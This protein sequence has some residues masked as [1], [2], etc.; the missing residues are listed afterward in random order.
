MRIIRLEVRAL[1]RFHELELDLPPGVTVIRGPNEAGK[2][3]VQRAIELALTR[4]AT[5]SWAELDQ[6]RP[7]DGRSPEPPAV[8]LE[9]V[10][11]EED[12]IRTGRLEK[13]FAGSKGT[14]RL[15]MNGEV[16]TDPTRA[17]E[18]LAELTGV[19]TEPFFRSTAS[20]HH[21]ELADLDR[22]EAN[23]RDRLQVTLSGADRGTSKAKKVLD[24]AIRDLTTRGEKNPGRL[25]VA[26]SAVAE[27]EAAMEAGEA[28]LA[29]LEHD[30]DALTQARVHRADVDGSLVERRSLLE[31]ARQAERLAADRA[32]AQDRYDRYRQAVTVSEELADLHE[33]HPSS[34]PLPVLR[35]LVERL[36]ALD[37][38]I[39]ELKAIL[40]DLDEAPTDELAPA[41][42]VGPWARRGILLALLGVVVAALWFVNDA[43]LEAATVPDAVLYLSLAMAAAGFLAAGFGYWLTRRDRSQLGRYR[44]RNLDRRLM[45]RSELEEELRI[46]EGDHVKQL[47]TLDLPDLPAA[48][49]LLAR[50]EAHVARIN[51]LSALLEGLVGREPAETLPRLRDAAA[52]EIEQKTSALEALG[53]I[54]KEPRARERLEAEVTELEA[55]LERARDQEANARARVEQNPIDAEQVAAS[56]ER[57]AAAREHLAA[58]ERR[59][60][61][62]EAA[63]RG[64]EQAEQETMEKATRYLEK[65]MVADLAAV[66]DGRYRRVRVDDT[67]LDIALFAP[68]KGDWV[69]VSQLSAGTRDL[70][71]LTARLGLVRLVTGDRRPPLLFD[72]P[73]V[74]FDDTR[75]TRAFRRLRE[76]T[77]D[78]QVLFMTTSE[79]YDELADKVY[80]LDGPDERDTVAMDGEG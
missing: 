64:I 7:W 34:E 23:L 2:T 51:E 5:S 13:V 8:S 6:M 10:S 33:G 45:G 79:R 24:R 66:T 67:S 44:I 62:Y 4:K 32:A 9:F 16:V 75:A 70:V 73:F 59:M 17:D 74:T 54:A 65:R 58:A 26:E 76:L 19:P 60:R 72:D 52:L 14:V 37:G 78:F 68:E 25:K 56:A 3:T 57:L 42:D 49:D 39:R 47:V 27:A 28:G 77:R 41:P 30:R 31:K 29:Q 21:H 38:R 36:R 12:G 11:E 61:V 53:P 35:Q 18:L 40:G 69:D 46:S 55:A 1:R 80:T 71:F 20:I 43:V 50:E 15:E 22:D 63:L 48:E